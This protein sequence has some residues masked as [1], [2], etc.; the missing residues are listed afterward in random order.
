MTKK[1]DQILLG[2]GLIVVVLALVAFV[3]F[4]SDRTESAAPAPAPTWPAATAPAEDH[5]HAA[6]SSVCR[7]GAVELR[8]AIDEGQA[9]VIDVRDLESYAAGHIDGAMHIPLSFI[10]SQIQYL[11]RDKMLVAYCT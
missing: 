4:R 3:A 9:A 1:M 5:H 7:I 6:E 2:G 10:E 8:A 11:P